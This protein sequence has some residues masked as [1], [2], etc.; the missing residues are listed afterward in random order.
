M[1]S[2]IE[3]FSLPAY[4]ILKR[5]YDLQVRYEPLCKVFFKPVILT[6]HIFYD[7]CVNLGIC[8]LIQL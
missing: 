4:Y 6:K 8:S 3:D 7:A 1:R 2:L 5:T